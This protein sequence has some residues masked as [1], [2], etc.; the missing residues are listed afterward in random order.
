M[1]VDKYEQ[2][3][4]DVE[5]L[6][7]PMFSG[8]YGEGGAGAGAGAGAAG[9]GG[10]GAGAGGERLLGG[11]LCLRGLL[12]LPAACLFCPALPCLPIQLRLL[13]LGTS[14]CVRSLTVAGMG[15]M[16]GMGG[17]MGGMGGM[18]AGG[19]AGMMGGMGG[20]MGGMGG[21]GGSGAGKSNAGH[22][23]C[24]LLALAVPELGG[25]GATVLPVF[26]P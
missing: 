23:S 26:R 3:K 2:R 7:A 20:G 8:L 22:I 5:A 25:K 11:W 19:M 13:N 17:M 9:M 12:S 15:G 1:P 4:K 14:M 21:F 18:G 6:T 24:L 10:M 16:G